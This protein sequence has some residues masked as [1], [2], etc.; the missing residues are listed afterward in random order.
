MSA[1]LALDLVYQYRKLLGKCEAGLGLEVDE[2]I[3][4]TAV[5]ASLAET[6]ADRWAVLRGAPGI[7]D[8]VRIVE[9]GPR[10]L[11]AKQT[12]YIEEGTRVEVV[13]EDAYEHLSYRFP[14]RVAQLREDGDDYAIVLELCGVP[15]LVHHGIVDHVEDAVD[16]IAK[17]VSQPEIK[18]AA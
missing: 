6:P 1:M 14:A 16:K 5:E 8:A 7:N 2:I 12:P 13:I 11:I 10:S 18:I 17:E 3:Q 15:V 4:L 9:V